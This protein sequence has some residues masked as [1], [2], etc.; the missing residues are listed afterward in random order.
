M[1]ARE[2]HTKAPDPSPA[3]IEDMCAEIRAKWPE[4]EHD[5]RRGSRVGAQSLDV[6]SGDEV[7]EQL[8]AWRWAKR[9][10]GQH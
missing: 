6:L 10:N 9:Q 2:Y 8:A 5:R 3:E 7:L 1:A 4:W